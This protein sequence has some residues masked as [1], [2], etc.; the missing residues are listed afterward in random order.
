MP[1]GILSIPRLMIQVKSWNLRG[2]RLTGITANAFNL[3][4]GTGESGKSGFLAQL[5]GVLLAS[6][7][8]KLSC[9]SPV[10][11]LMAAVINEV[12]RSSGGNLARKRGFAL[13]SSDKV[14]CGGLS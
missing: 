7:S 11:I 8:E 9:I 2:T 14:K 1:L 3:R 13:R 12:P 10:T 4:N 5:R 6:G